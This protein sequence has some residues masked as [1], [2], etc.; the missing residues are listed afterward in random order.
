MM[1]CFLLENDDRF[2]A[3]RH[4]HIEERGMLF[5]SLW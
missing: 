2:E 5:T 1:G 3:E 4:C